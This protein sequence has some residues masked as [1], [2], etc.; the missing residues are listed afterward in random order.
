[1]MSTDQVCAPGGNDPARVLITILKSRRIIPESIA[2]TAA[3]TYRPRQV[4]NA[5]AGGEPLSY[6]KE[7]EEGED[8]ESWISEKKWRGRGG[9]GAPL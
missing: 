2:T 4:A 1:M 8:D 5:E 3:A 9:A 6:Q 7:D